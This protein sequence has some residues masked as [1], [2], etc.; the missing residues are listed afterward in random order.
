MVWKNYKNEI[1][2]YKDPRS[3][4]GA[5]V[6]ISNSHYP[7]DSRIIEYEKSGRI[8]T[9]DVRTGNVIEKKPTGVQKKS[10]E[11]QYLSGP[12]VLI[13]TCL[14]EWRPCLG[15]KMWIVG[16]LLIRRS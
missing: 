1:D 7:Y 4:M 2:R 13:S 5:E 10:K 8:S 11:S 12:G 3:F 6:S 15:P 16:D 9:C 14:Y